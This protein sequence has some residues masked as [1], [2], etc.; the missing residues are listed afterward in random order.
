MTEMVGL[1]KATKDNEVRA[2]ILNEMRAQ[3][4]QALRLR[5]GS[6][7]AWH[8]A[9]VEALIEKQL[10]VKR[11]PQMYLARALAMDPQ[12]LELRRIKG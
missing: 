2:A 3:S 1:L 8:M 10:G 7:A 12:N 5:P 11:N 6:S 4:A 9:G